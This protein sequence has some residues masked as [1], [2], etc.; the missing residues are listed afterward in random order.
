MVDCLFPARSKIE[1]PPPVPKKSP[2]KS[3]THKKRGAAAGE[4]DDELSKRR[5]TDDK[6]DEVV[7]EKAVDVEDDTKLLSGQDNDDD[8]EL[9]GEESFSEPASKY[10]VRQ[11]VIARDEDGLMY[12][13]NI[14]RKMH[15]INHQKSVSCLNCIDE[16]PNKDKKD[17]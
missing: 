15:G 16:F 10:E 7:N 8:E 3:S 9:A 14:R 13:A 2:A 12:H 5:R 4:E 1:N 6:D 11:R 17:V